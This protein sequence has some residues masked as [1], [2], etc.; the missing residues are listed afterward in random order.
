SKQLGLFCSDR[1]PPCAYTVASRANKAVRFTN[2][3]RAE[4]QI[5]IAPRGKRGAIILRSSPPTNPC[6]ATD[7]K[8]AAFNI[9]STAFR[10]PLSA[11]CPA[12]SSEYH[13]TGFRA[14]NSFLAAM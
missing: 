1:A 11:F 10:W 4:E 5:G 8:P 6:S 13:V 7:H 2:Q 14:L 12:G 9:D 3:P